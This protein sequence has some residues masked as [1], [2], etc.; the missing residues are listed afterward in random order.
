VEVVD[1]VRGLAGADPALIAQSHE[2]VGE[3]GSLLRGVDLFGNSGEGIPAVVWVVFGDR[4]SESLEVRSDQ[5]GQLDLKGE[6]D[7]GEIEQ[8]LP[9]S[10]ECLLRKADE[11]LDGAMGERSDARAGELVFGRAT[12][13]AA[14]VLGF[15]A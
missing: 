12:V 11:F 8:V 10:V 2:G 5:F 3:R 9:Q 1:R 13:L 6:S 7:G 15:A 14:A 4:L